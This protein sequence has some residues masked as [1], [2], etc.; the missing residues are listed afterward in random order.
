MGCKLFFKSGGVGI[1]SWIIPTCPCGWQGG[2]HYAHNDYQHSNAREE[3]QR[4]HKKVE[5]VTVGL[6]K[7]L[8]Q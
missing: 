2:K 1:E 5:K 8:E 7:E 3:Y 4:L 6:L